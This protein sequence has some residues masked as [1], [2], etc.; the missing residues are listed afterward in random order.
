MRETSR[1]ATQLRRSPATLIADIA[2]NT[3]FG[4]GRDASEGVGEHFV[5]VV[6][7]GHLGVVGCGRQMNGDSHLVKIVCYNCLVDD[8][9]KQLL[10][11]NKPDR[12]SI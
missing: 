2:K 3:C 8:H 1:R 9:F 10:A 5:G 4:W 7:V 12:E 6:G 11:V